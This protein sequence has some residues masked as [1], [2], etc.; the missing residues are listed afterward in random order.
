MADVKRLMAL[1]MVPELAKEVATQID[2]AAASVTADSITIGPIDE[3]NFDFAGG[4]LQDFA[5]AI[6]A[7]IPAPA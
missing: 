3:A 7:A 6:A 5:E 2:T 1:S 4:S